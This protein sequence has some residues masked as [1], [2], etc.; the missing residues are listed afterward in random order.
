[1]INCV[2]LAWVYKFF[3]DV[4]DADPLLTFKVGQLMS[5][6]FKTV[7]KH[8]ANRKKTKKNKHESYL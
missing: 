4:I 2:V 3:K 1:M 7:L 5:Q 6:F 8:Q